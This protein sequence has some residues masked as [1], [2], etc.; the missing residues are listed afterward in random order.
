MIAMGANVNRPKTQAF[1]RIGELAAKLGLNPKTIRY[2]EEVGLLPEPPRTAA[3]YRLYT[4]DDYQRLHFILKAKK[5]GLT[6]EE[7][8]EILA[9]RSQGIQPCEHVLALLDR[10]IEQ[11]DQQL[12]AL[13]DFRQELLEMRED[14]ST[15]MVAEG[16]FCCI[17]EDHEYSGE[18]EI[19]LTALS[20]VQ[21]GKKRR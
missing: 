3:G 11:V 15:G 19:A 5:I 6:L 10:K 9:V 16:N 13:S 2:Y 18:H 17:I 8:G 4:Q 12:A 7:I 14:A 1:L 21:P 20:N